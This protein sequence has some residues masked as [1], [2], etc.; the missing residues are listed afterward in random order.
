MLAVR[1]T[2]RARTGSL[3]CSSRLRSA[4]SRCGAETGI[5]IPSDVVYLRAEGAARARWVSPPARQEQAAATKA[6]W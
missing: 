2:G 4:I 3:T 6:G 5:V 1:A